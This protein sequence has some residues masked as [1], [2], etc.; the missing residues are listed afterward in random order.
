[1]ALTPFADLTDSVFGTPMTPVTGVPGE[2]VSHGVP[3]RRPRVQHPS[4]NICLKA[5]VIF[6]VVIGAIALVTGVLSLLAS[7]GVLPHGMNSIAV[8]AQI[9]MVNSSLMAGGGL[10]LFVFGLVAWACQH[11]DPTRR[12]L[13]SRF[14]GLDP[15]I[16]N[17][18]QV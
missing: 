3:G 18:P 9:G 14:K 16:D 1:M 4:R 8:L 17:T 11:R 10:S 2:T 5:F 7:N 6:V 15:S 12:N 13:N